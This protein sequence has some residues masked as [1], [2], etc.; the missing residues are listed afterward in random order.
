[1]KPNWMIRVFILFAVLQLF[2]IV[3]GFMVQNWVRVGVGLG[4]AFLMLGLVRYMKKQVLDRLSFGLLMLCI[5]ENSLEILY[6]F[7]SG[8][9]KEIPW[10]LAGFSI[11][12][13][14][15]WYAEKEDSLRWD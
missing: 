13:V 6:Y 7:I 5:F 14:I 2:I 3:Q 10:C 8:M 4:N 15:I 9:Y 11:C 1:M 12:V